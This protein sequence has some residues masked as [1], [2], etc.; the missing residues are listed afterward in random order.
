M[1]LFTIDE[2]RKTFKNG[3][4]EEEILKGIN[5][6]L[7][8]GEITALVGASGSGKSTLLTI[9][10]GLQPA[11]DGQVFFEEQN[12]TTMSTEQVRK[13]RASKFGFVF[14]FAHLVPFLTVEE[15]LLLMLDVAESRLKKYEQQHEVNHLLQLIGMAHRKTAYPSSL[16]GGEKQRVAIARAIIHQPKVLFADE[17]TASL[18]SPRSK[19]IMLLLRE[20]T[21]T[22]KI[23]TLMVTHDEEMLAYAD[24]IIKMSDGLV[25]PNAMY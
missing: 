17:P 2:V 8:E 13:L 24:R 12:L 11:T 14:Q 9:A 25:L 10:A 4:V 6:S 18:D 19:E 23:T 15:Q 5:L 22:L 16:S 21:K 7:K 3:E 1:T 20:L